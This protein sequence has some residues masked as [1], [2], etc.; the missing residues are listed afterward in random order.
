LGTCTA[1]DYA[2]HITVTLQLVYS[3][4][5]HGIGFQRRTSLCLWDYGCGI[6][7]HILVSQ[8]RQFPTR[9]STS[10]Y[11][12]LPGRGCPSCTTRQWVPVLSSPTTCKATVEIIECTVDSLYSYSIITDCKENAAFNISSVLPC[13]GWLILFRLYTASA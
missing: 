6:H 2:S 1:H 8:F 4:T 3:V 5:L 13:I 12:H 10:P 11:L 7:D 9:W